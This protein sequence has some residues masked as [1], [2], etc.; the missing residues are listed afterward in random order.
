MKSARTGRRPGDSGTRDA[1]LRAA[2]AQFRE[3]GFERTSLRGVAREAGVDPAL[4]VHYCG[5]KAG[6]FV[7]AFEWRFEP[8]RRMER[9]LRRGRRHAGEEL[10]RLF[11]E[12]WDRERSR[13]PLITLLRSATVEPAAAELMRD[14]LREV[15]SPLVRELD[16][17]EPDLRTSLV[18]SQLLGHA[19]IRHVV[20]LDP[21]ATGD[22]ETI[23][24]AVAPTLQRY[25]TEGLA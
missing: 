8:R 4:V 14:V 21:L 22:A 2:A 11:L 16:A 3:R 5:G 23:V 7:A 20:E 10:A 9:I 19:L 25:L 12:I 18:A 1:I 24:A 15:L 17:D 6:L 13:H